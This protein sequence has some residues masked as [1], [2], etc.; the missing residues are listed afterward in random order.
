MSVG[1]IMD[2]ATGDA[3]AYDRVLERMHL[4]DRAPEG[5]VF[6][7][8]GPYGDG[9]RV[10]DVWRDAG[11]FQQFAEDQ[12]GPHAGAEGLPEPKV[13][14][15][16]VDEMLDERD[17]GTGDVHHL[18]VVRLSMD[19]QTFH[20]ADADIRQDQRSPA[21]C[22]F[23]VN[24]PSNGGWMVIDAWTD[25]DTLDEFIQTKVG[26]AMQARDMPPPTIEDVPL[27]KT[28]ASS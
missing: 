23:H 9:W 6:H 4:T 28:L 21:G 16:Q 7:A 20:D 8:A 13:E 19:G 1:V 12:I 14:M 15:V 11:T 26:P 18:Q 25:K 27:H 10:V 22:K 3:A 2:F 24:G 5:C 17:G